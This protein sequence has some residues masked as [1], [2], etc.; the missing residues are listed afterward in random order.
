M[1]KNH[2]CLHILIHRKRRRSAKQSCNGAGR[3]LFDKDTKCPRPKFETETPWAICFW[4]LRLWQGR[5]SH[6]LDRKRIKAIPGSPWHC[7]AERIA[8]PHQ[9]HFNKN[10][11]DNDNNQIENNSYCQLITINICQSIKLQ[12]TKKENTFWVESRLCTS[13]APRL[14]GSVCES[15]FLS[16]SSALANLRSS[17]N[18]QRL[19]QQT[20]FKLIHDLRIIFYM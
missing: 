3:Q 2:I 15:F 16:S 5:T 11:N 4:E 19:N 20:L 17:L 7:Y 10:D 14:K 12:T 18:S 1:Q 13:F 9:T 8:A 6:S